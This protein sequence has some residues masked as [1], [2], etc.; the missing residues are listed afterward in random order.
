MPYTDFRMTKTEIS[1][2]QGYN[3]TRK[4]W[5]IDVMVY[6]ADLGADFKAKM[7]HLFTVLMESPGLGMGCYATNIEKVMYEGNV[8][9]VDGLELDF[10]GRTKID[11]VHRF[12]VTTYTTGSD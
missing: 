4:V 2:A 6:Q 7:V 9:T 3:H 5:Q 12:T 8:G 1:S 11:Q 10:L